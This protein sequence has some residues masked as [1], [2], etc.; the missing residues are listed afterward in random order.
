MIGGFMT[1]NVG[2]ANAKQVEHLENIVESEIK[3]LQNK[4]PSNVGLANARQVAH[5]KKVL[6]SEVKELQNKTI[7][8]L[9]KA[10][11]TK[12]IVI[13]FSL[14]TTFL[15][16]ITHDDVLAGFREWASI[17]ALMTSA[18]TSGFALWESVF[19]LSEP[20]GGFQPGS[21]RRKE[22]T[23]GIRISEGVREQTHSG[24]TRR[25]F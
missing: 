6:E 20:L 5:F 17:A 19:F 7:F 3:Q 23:K 11:F 9:G 18:V 24:E 4:T 22:D 14:A 1:D 12:K 8:N 15:I 25:A 21:E 10:F 16:G 2:L 13:I